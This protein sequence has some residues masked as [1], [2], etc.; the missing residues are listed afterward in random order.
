MLAAYLAQGNSLRGA[1]RTATSI[2]LSLSIWL[3]AMTG[4]AWAEPVSTA[5]GVGVPVS[6]R[7]TA[8]PDRRPDLAGGT[9]RHE[10]GDP[11]VYE[12]L[13]LEL[14]N[15]ARA[16][17]AAEAARFGI[18]LN[19]S[20]P[21]GTI[22]ATPKPPLAFHPLLIT[23]ARGHSDWL[24]AND[25]F[26]HEGAGGN[27]PGDRMEAAGYPFAGQWGWG[28][29][30]AW[31]GTTGTPNLTDYT[32]AEHENLFRSHGHRENLMNAD[33]D[34]IGI[35]VR[36]GVF[37]TLGTNGKLVN[38]NAVMAAQNFALSGGTPGPLV[39]GVVYQDTN[40]DKAYSVG[41]GL[42]GV[43]VSPATGSGYAV[44]SASGGFA[45]PTGQTSGTLAVTI[46]GPGVAAPITKNV[47]VAATNVKV[48]FEILG[49]M[50]LGF[51]PDKSGF[52]PQQR[53]QFELTGPLG[54]K[55]QVSYSADLKIWMTLGTYN[56]ASGKLTVV[57]ATTK[58]TMRFYRA[59]IVP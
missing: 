48:D 54:A 5:A 17:P 57:D 45:F 8:P 32:V 50:P 25:V 30:I 22:S 42:A 27:T 56:L 55:A 24:L 40:G 1:T 6:A 3:G 19:D 12:Q 20:L 9:V 37:T 53:F 11:T 34:E 38:Y 33:F 51:T 7:G 52:N 43:T 39:L 15:R 14:V 28:E 35:G 46:S 23:A 58:Q 41:E 16:N 26:T 2:T 18:D 4:A 36:S 44:T 49:D 10:H 47:T 29:N 21:P 13:M 31:K 59:V